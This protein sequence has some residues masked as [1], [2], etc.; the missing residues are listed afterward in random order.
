MSIQT[1]VSRE[2]A[3]WLVARRETT[4]ATNLL[5]DAP[6]DPVLRARADRARVAQNEA[7]TLLRAALAA[8]GHSLAD[9]Q[10]ELR[11]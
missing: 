3:E 5:N 1:D 2:L 4:V 6:E 8:R 11:G 7:Q 10:A 9:L